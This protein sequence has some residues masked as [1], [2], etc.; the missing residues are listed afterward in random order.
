MA[1]ELDA[2]GVLH[3]GTGPD[4]PT[5]GSN[6]FDWAKEDMVLNDEIQAVVVGF[7][8]HFNL[9]KMT[10]VSFLC[11]RTGKRKKEKKKKKKKKKTKKKKEK[12]RK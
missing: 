3:E 12:K 7:D 5:P 4:F 8:P 6:I 2:V 10:K 11:T 9:V 1:S